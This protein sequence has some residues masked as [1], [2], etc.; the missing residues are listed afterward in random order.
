LGKKHPKRKPGF[1]DEYSL[2]AWS[3]KGPAP[4]IGCFVGGIRDNYGLPLLLRISIPI[5]EFPEGP[6]EFEGSLSNYGFYFLVS[7]YGC[8][9]Q[10]VNFRIEFI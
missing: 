2:R 1:A 10:E 5:S 9:V 4:G 6:F 7:S 3:K 8:E